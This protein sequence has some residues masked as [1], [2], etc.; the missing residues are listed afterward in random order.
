[1]PNLGSA[2]YCN[3]S[4]VN[5]VQ[6]RVEDNDGGARVQVACVAACVYWASQKRDISGWSNSQCGLVPPTNPSPT[7]NYV[8]LILEAA[9]GLLLAALI[10]GICVRRKK[11]KDA[12]NAEAHD[13]NT[14]M[15]AAKYQPLS[16][17][18]TSAS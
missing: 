18:L 8:P 2:I 17:E 9:G 14:G 7:A 13:A 4:T 3:Q 5:L 12:A 15:D 11:A 16:Q 10:I 6:T 1:M